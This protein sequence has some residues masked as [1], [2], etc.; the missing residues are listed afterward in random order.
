MTRLFKISISVLILPALLTAASAQMAR[1]PKISPDDLQAAQSETRESGGA[2]AEL[3][4][5]ARLDA[6]QKGTYDSLIVIYAKAVKG[7]KD[8]FAVIQRGGAKFPLAFDKQGR[9]LKSGDKFLRMGLRHEEGKSPV[10]RLIGQTSDP[11]QG[12]QQRNL[13]FQFNG[14]E[15]ALISQSTTSLAK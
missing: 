10:L 9:A 4:Y 11:K 6:V 15:F 12:D 2:N 8:Y 1:N 3:I 13:D 5:A 14:G 7:G